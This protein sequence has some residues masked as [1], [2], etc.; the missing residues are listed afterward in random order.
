MGSMSL[1]VSVQ[2]SWHLLGFI[3]I[4]KFVYVGEILSKVLVLKK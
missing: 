4:Q 2:V 3:R 1:E